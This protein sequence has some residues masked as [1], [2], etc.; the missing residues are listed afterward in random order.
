MLEYRVMR[1]IVT[2]SACALLSAAAGPAFAD[3]VVFDRSGAGTFLQLDFISLPGG[4][5]DYR[6]DVESSIPVTFQI[7]AGYVRHWD[8]FVAPPPRPHHEFLDGNTSG[9]EDGQDLFGQSG[10]WLFTVPDT[11][12]YFFNAGSEYED[13]GVP[14]GTPLYEVVNY[15]NPY[16][17]VFADDIDQGL[18]FTYRFKVTRLGAAAV[19]EPAVWTLLIAGFG[20]AGAALRRGRRGQVGP[21]PVSSP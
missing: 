5:G 1:A 13:R 4:P 11:E 17:S 15:E 21:A 8:I 18:R 7:R 10:S 9:A 20:L 12:F 19:P 6:F 3:V 14:E 16:F 2:A